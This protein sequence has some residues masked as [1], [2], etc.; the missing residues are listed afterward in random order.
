MGYRIGI[1]VGG[2]FT[3]VVLLDEQTGQTSI[4]KV[5]SSRDDPS[6]PVIEGARQL[7]AQAG[8][9]AGEIVHAVHGCTIGT[10]AVI[11][12]TGV[13]IGLI[14][15]RGF[16]GMLEIGRLETLDPYSFR[17]GKIKPL[18]P[19]GM[20]YEIGG[21]ISGTGVEIEPLPEDEI[22]GIGKALVEQG[23]R[24]IAISLVNAYLNPEHEHRVAET[25]RRLHPDLIVLS[26]ARLW[27]EIGEYERANV[28]ILNGYIKPL[29]DAYN[30]A[31]EAGLGGQG[32]TAPVFLPKLNGGIATVSQTSG[33]P[34]ATVTSG[35]T[36]GAQAAAE[37]CRIAG[38]RQ[39]ITLDIGGTSADFAVIE[40]F[41]PVFSAGATVGGF[42]VSMPSVWVRSV[43]AGGGSI[44]A[45]DATGVLKVGPR[46]AGSRPGPACYGR[47][48]ELPTVSDA[49][50]AAGYLSTE[51]LLAGRDRL[52]LAAAN[53][54]VG[55]LAEKFGRS[56]PEVA[57]SIIRIATSHM[58]REILS[59]LAEKGFDR[60]DSV[61][62]AFGG[63]GPTQAHWIIDDLDL[64]A[65]VIPLT[66]GTLSA[67]GGV[68]SPMKED[69]VLSFN[70]PTSA[71]RGEALRDGVAALERATVERLVETGAARDAISIV[72][73]ADMKYRRQ[74]F[75]ITVPIAEC[76]ARDDLLAAIEEAFHATHERIYGHRNQGA[77]VA[78]VN[79]RVSG[80]SELARVTLAPALPDTPGAPVGAR[81][82]F[83]KGAWHEAKVFARHSL[84]RGQQIPGPC[85]VEQDDTTTV[86]PPG[87]SLS[88][89]D[90]GMLFLTKGKA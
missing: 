8:L 1:D 90:S 7:I 35:L 67:L 88:V 37:V 39:A 54:V 66:P 36:A 5:P 34:I 85:I 20:V 70:L 42:A 43:G 47:G 3:D 81:R 14:V 89:H 72:V 23:A 62:I 86:V 59:M 11:E 13:K 50:L 19:R 75:T 71:L 41:E 17:S 24:A 87:F 25:L 58:S 6:A 9:S 12:R 4:L 52:D 79:L 15:T 69:S 48:G 33:N 16:K 61:L 83:H 21:R 60:R 28:A 44:A 27:P 46:S 18:V 53:R 78:L 68:L 82:L 30:S 65:A 45:I 10:N 40:D 63:A 74:A 29:M 84:A 77:E 73:S 76:F 2:T 80:R 31:V 56:I 49:Y 55:D 64:K 57:E 22:A 26:G 32:I 38:L 51:T